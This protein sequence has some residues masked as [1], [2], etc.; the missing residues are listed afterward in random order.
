[1]RK[2]VLAGVA[3]FFSV[4]LALAVQVSFVKYDKEKKELTVKDKEGKETSY[5][6]TDKTEFKAKGKDGTE[7]DIPNDKG[8]AR[9][10]KMKEGSKA[11]FDIETEKH[12]LKSLTFQGGR[13]KKK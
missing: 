3:L 5:K 1:M 11:R 7:K 12:D 9:L 10:E 13:G 6:V 4:G 8:V 2:F